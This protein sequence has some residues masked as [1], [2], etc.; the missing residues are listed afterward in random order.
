MALLFTALTFQFEIVKISFR[1]LSQGLLQN[2]CIFGE[3]DSP[4]IGP[5]GIHPAP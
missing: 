3:A 4:G 2:F 1:K 5:V